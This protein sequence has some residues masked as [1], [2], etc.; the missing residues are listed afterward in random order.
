MTEIGPLGAAILGVFIGALASL[1]Y[2]LIWRFRYT[3]VVRRD[4]VE[5]S[6]AVTAGKVY[7]QL[8]PYLPEFDY[9]PRDVRFI[10]SPVDLIVFDGLDEGTVHEVVF[11][12]VKTGGSQ[13]SP[14]ERAVREAI[15]G[16]RVGWRLLRQPD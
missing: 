16:G 9:N 6:R 5:R 4:A 13:L 15:E 3:R 10:G 14:R 2:H 7:E 11:V 12:E 1:G 8:V